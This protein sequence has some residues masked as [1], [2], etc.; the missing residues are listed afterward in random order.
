MKGMLNFLEKAGLVTR[1]APVGQMH[2]EAGPTPVAQ[3]EP[4]RGGQPPSAVVGTPLK[5][6]EIYASAGVAPS[7][8][9]AE[10][11][12]RLVDGLQ[13]MDGA[14]RLLA[15]KA[16]DAADESWSIEDPLADAEAK[17][18]ALARYAEHL[19]HELQTMER[20][21]AARLQ[22]VASRQDKTVGEIRKQIV[23]LE[24]LASREIVRSAHD[25][26]VHE[27][28]LQA[29]RQRTAGQLETIG[30]TSQRLQSLSMQFGAAPA[31]RKE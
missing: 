13:A 17:L 7:V 26:A 15:I 18:Q 14:T 27:A 28:E 25:S 19:Q 22:A 6:D 9:P 8:Y 5:L 21:T 16:M 24:A 2:P 12:L 20:A 1:D 31:D 30:E 29:A 11:L 23:E 10:R 4:E 3:P